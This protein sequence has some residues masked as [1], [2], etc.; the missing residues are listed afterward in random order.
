MSPRKLV[1]LA[2]AGVAIAGTAVVVVLAA[3]G[4]G[5]PPSAPLE[6][7]AVVLRTEITPARLLSGD[8]TTAIVELTVDTGRGDPAKIEVAP[9]FRP[10]YR[11]GAVTVERAELGSRLVARYRYPIQCVVRACAPGASTGPL[12]LPIG[13]VRYT[14]REGDVVSL[15][16]EWP[17]VEI[18]S[19]LSADELRAVQLAPADLSA[20][21]DLD[22]VPEPGFRGGPALYGWLFVGL[23]AVLL[24]AVGGTVA[25]RLWPR[26]ERVVPLETRPAVPPLRAALDGVESSLADDDVEPRRAALEELARQLAGEGDE[27]LA[28][29]ARRLAWSRSGPEADR[30][31][32]LLA[33]AAARGERPAE[34][35]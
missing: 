26:G 20:V 31:R 3:A 23:A 35:G 18:V 1:A 28:R 5:E 6:A 33:R 7:D 12:A 34:A 27:E 16:L 19:R 30:V 17:Q 22:A 4:D 8:R 14:P 24:L 13:L 9:V 10:F 2:A 29:E 25:W 11:V 32:T 21:Q 15:P